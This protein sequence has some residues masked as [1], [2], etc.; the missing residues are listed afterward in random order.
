MKTTMFVAAVALAGSTAF[1]SPLTAGGSAAFPGY[2]VAPVLGSPIATLNTPFVYSGIG[3]PF[4][5]ILTS[6]VYNEAGFLTF[7][8]HVTNTSTTTEAF[9]AF[10]V[11]GFGGWLIDAGISPIG[12]GPFPFDIERSLSD[13]EVTSLFADTGNPI[14]GRVMPGMTSGPTILRTNATDF[15]HS[16]G[17]VINGSVAGNIDILAPIPTPGAGALLGLGTLAAFRRRR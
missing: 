11:N 3:T 17:A 5:G 7:V 1:A 2:V 8:Y 12:P 14:H 10:T 9:G 4:S 16:I 15:G 13:G 6:E